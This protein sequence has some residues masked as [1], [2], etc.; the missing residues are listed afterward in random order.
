MTLIFVIIPVQKKTLC[1]LKDYSSDVGEELQDLFLRC[2]GRRCKF[3]AYL[4]VKIGLPLS[5]IGG[6]V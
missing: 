1:C 3:L 2:L 4:K 6:H 5:C